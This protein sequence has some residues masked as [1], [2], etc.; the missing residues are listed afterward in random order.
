MTRPR[1]PRAAVPL[2]DLPSRYW[3]H[4][5]HVRWAG[6]P[7]RA[8]DHV[9]VGPSGVHVIR[10]LP[11][12]GST[13][14]PDARGHGLPDALVTTSAE[15]A[16]VVRGQLPSRYH[17]R[18]RP[19]V[20]VLGAGDL[21]E[22]VDGVLVVSL[23]TFENLLVA[24]RAVL[25]TSEVRAVSSALQV[26]RQYVVPAP[27]AAPRRGHAFLRAAAATLAVAAALVGILVADP[28]VLDVFRA[29]S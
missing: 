6:R 10:Y 1:Q 13:S 28:S 20:C 22:D 7:A 29:R 24:S 27:T 16:E 8:I 25:S 18:V 11:T 21:A 4:L 12:A 26:D 2:A 9:L 17:D 5:W 15:E 23:G 14:A 3:S 19:V